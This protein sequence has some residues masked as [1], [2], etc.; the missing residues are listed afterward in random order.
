MVAFIP[1]ERGVE[2]VLFNSA[3]F[4]IFFP[5]VCA[6][7]FLTR[8]SRRWL[9]LLL[10]SYYFY[11]SWK[12]GYLIL[13]VVSTLVDYL[14]AK[15]MS[16]LPDRASRRPY[17]A[18]SIVV[19]LGLLFT[20]K[21]FDF[22][23]SSLEGV[24]AASGWFMTLPRLDLLLPVG[25]SF[26]TFQTLSYTIDVYR[27]E[28]EPERHLG[29]FALFVAFFPQ[30]VAG[31]IER[32]GR[33]L[34]QF[35]TMDAAWDPVRVHQGFQ[36]MLRGFVKKTCI[37]DRAALYVDLVYANPA[38]YSTA[39]VVAATYLFAIQIYCDFSGY[40]D[41]AIGSAKVMG[42]ELSENFRRPYFATSFADFWRR[43]HISLSTFFRDYVYIP[44]GG[45]RSGLWRG[46]FNVFATFVIS[47]LWHGANWTFVAWGALHGLYLC[48]ERFIALAR[49]GRVKVESSVSRFLSAV[50]V[51]HL[52]LVAWVF[53]RAR[54]V[55]EA[56]EIL[57]RVV[58]LVPDTATSVLPA[59]PGV[60]AYLNAPAVM[61]DFGVLALLLA[62]L[63]VRERAT[64]RAEPYAPGHFRRWFGYG[65]LIAVIMFVGRW[66]AA[67]FIY[68][69]F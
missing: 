51:F 20:F 48:G 5:C 67:E 49:A 61:F 18:L 22:F 33:L 13:I 15:R 29:R 46:L 55:T 35:V 58:G 63:F 37:A 32:A 14:A 17:L 12:P 34:P 69:Q 8:P 64:E 65:W 42:I 31:P 38:G 23:A 52:V 56:C 9:L 27:G 6:L 45:N 54:S 57:G 40:S 50:F 26:Y 44:L 47:G 24:V 62:A 28:L 2:Q 68:F 11:A 10:A 25:I 3:H 53:F 16:G 41:I 60:W 36:Q 1:C 66:G 7:F 21:Y 39:W 59:L 43:W 30:L 19:N 4:L